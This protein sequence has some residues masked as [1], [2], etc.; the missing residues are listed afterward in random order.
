MSYT[1]KLLKSRAKERQIP[2]YVSNADSH[3]LTICVLVSS[4]PR[5]HK[6][7]SVAWLAVLLPFASLSN[8][9]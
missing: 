2:S 7:A 1:E 9:R 5:V 8:V 3:T 4:C 6:I